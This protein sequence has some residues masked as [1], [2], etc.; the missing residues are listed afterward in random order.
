MSICTLFVI[1]PNRTPDMSIGGFIISEFYLIDK[2]QGIY[3]EPPSRDIMT[4]S[5]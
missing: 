5:D 2:E 4:Y 3:E 1:K